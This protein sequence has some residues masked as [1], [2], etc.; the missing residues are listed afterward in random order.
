MVVRDSYTDTHISGGE[1]EGERNLACCVLQ[2]GLALARQLVFDRDFSLEVGLGEVDTVLAAAVAVRLDVFVDVDRDGPH[3]DRPDG[4]DPHGAAVCSAGLRGAA[5]A[6]ALF[7]PQRNT[8]CDSVEGD[9]L[10]EGVRVSDQP[11][12]CIPS[13]TFKSNV[14]RTLSPDQCHSPPGAS[15]ARAGCTAR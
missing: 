13:A 1:R 5:Q 4:G 9:R 10:G 11:Y 14:H 12:I 2:E 8:N 7:R 3:G 15:R 6:E